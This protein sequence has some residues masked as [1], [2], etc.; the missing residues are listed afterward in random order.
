MKWLTLACLALAVAGCDYSVPL[1]KSPESETDGALI[2]LWRSAATNSAPEDL[3]VLPLGRKEYLVSY[4]ANTKDAMFARCCLCQAAD[5]RFVQLEWFGTGSGGVA[6]DNKVFQFA[7]YTLDGDTLKVR[8]LNADTVGRSA[9]TSAELAAAVAEKK[10]S[11]NLLRE[12]MAFKRVERG[13][14]KIPDLPPAG[15]GR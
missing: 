5:R 12:E 6:E 3:L 10:D 15:G 7:A 13:R 1:V 8:L 4:P 11:P 9:A 2:G 14:D